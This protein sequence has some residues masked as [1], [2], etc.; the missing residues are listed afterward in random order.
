MSRKTMNLIAATALAVTATIALQARAGDEAKTAE[1]VKTAKTETAT[2]EAGA[3]AS[4]LAIGENAPDFTLTDT[5]GKTHHLA[6]YMKAG[7][8]VVLEWFNPDC[9][10]VKKHHVANT[11]MAETFKST[12]GKEVVWLAINSGGPGLQ[13]NGLERNVTAK[14]EYGIEYPILLDETGMVGKMY[15]AK[16]TPHMMI[17][18]HGKLA[19]R[20][21]LDN[22]KSPQTVGDINYVKTALESCTQHKPIAVSE[23]RSYGCSVKYAS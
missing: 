21:P 18:D 14:K 8:I 16:T 22:D 3:E 4:V 10:F 9:P 7:N 17:I 6:D 23:E 5:E 11:S 15:G 13:G 19:Y 20:G 1:T 12:K 2:P